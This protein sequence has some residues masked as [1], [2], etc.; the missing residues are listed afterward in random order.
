M[1]MDAVERYV[2]DEKG[3]RVAVILPL[4]EYEKMQEDLHDLAVVA[5]RRDEKTFSLDELKKRL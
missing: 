2:V 1:S 4:E 5:E 3:Q